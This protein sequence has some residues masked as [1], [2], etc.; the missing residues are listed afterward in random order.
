VTRF[1][2]VLCTSTTSLLP[3]T[4]CRIFSQ[5][6][7]SPLTNHCSME[8][9]PWGLTIWDLTIRD[10]VAPCNNSAPLYP[11]R[12][13]HLPH[14]VLPHPTPSPLLPLPPLSTVVLATPVM[15]SSLDSRALRLFPTPRQHR[16]ALP[17]LLSW[18]P[19]SLTLPLFH[20]LNR[21]PL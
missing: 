1:F 19:H 14:P 11:I 8:Y 20:A 4:S 2:L 5:S 15:T 21:S 16:L 9:D 6:V 7:A 18:V 3:P 12:Y 10:V 13:P 17:C